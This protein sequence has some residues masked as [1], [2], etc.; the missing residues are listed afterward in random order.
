MNIVILLAFLI[1]INL[2]TAVAFAWD[3]SLARRGSRRM[4]EATLL[5]LAF[6]GGTPAAYWARH[7][8]R[9]KTR[10]QPFSNQLHFIAFLQ[11]AGLC[12]AFWLF[13]IQ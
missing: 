8:F 1:V 13:V 6:V 12:I 3:K 7:R 11:L 9:H 5:S 10:K 4:A 2:A